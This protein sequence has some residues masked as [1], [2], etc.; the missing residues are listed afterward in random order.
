MVWGDSMELLQLRYFYESAVNESFSKTAKSHMVPITSVSASIKR[1][2]Q[3]LGCDL[4][5]R[6][7]NRVHLSEAGKRFY[8]SIRD[9]FA[10]L[11]KAVK[12]L[13]QAEEDRPIRLLV[14]D[15]RP[16]I[17]NRVIEFR[18]LNPAAD[19]YLTMNR[20]NIDP[21]D[22]DVIIDER[23]SR[24]PGWVEVPLR[25]YHL[26]F[27]CSERN[28]LANRS[29]KL[30]DLENEAFM[31]YE[32]DGNLYRRMLKTCREAG[33][34][35]RVVSMCNDVQCYLRLL[36]AGLGI[37]LLKKD[38]PAIPGTKYMDVVDFDQVICFAAYYRPGKERTKINTFVEY[39][40]QI[41]E[42]D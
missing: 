22:Y 2:E 4:F 12:S 31:G 9:M 6:S 36:A 34:E 18:K 1:L 24:Y 28:P 27:V 19:F 33:F 39:M 3:E 30:R 7:S 21:E 10:D 25:E 29:V 35:P 38:A 11:D 40:K 42:N 23:C 37:A 26:S 14:L 16:S 15:M 13:G 8:E 41:Y 5:V 17:T 32:D 20:K